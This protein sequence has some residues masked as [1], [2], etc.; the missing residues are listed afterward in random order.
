[1]AVSLLA[2][3][4]SDLCLGKPVLKSLSICATVGDALSVLKRFGENYISV[5]NCDHHRHN[6]LSEADKGL[7]ECRCVGKVCMVNIISFLCKEEN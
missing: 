1:M 3:E 5:W 4:V 2:R 7:E 6:N